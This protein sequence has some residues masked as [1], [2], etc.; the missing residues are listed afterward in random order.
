MN[1]VQKEDA[2]AAARKNR[3]AK[4]PE[5]VTPRAV[6]R[7]QALRA[8]LIAAAEKVIAG[9]GLAGLNARDLAEAVGCSLGAI[10]NVF[11]HLDAVV[12]EV[13]SRTLAMFEAFVARR[14]KRW[15]SAADGDAV[16]GLVALAEAYLDFAVTHYERWRT[17][18]VHERSAGQDLPASYVADQERLFLLVEKPLGALRPDLDDK[19]RAL[20]ARTMFAAVHGVVTLSLDEKVL[21]LPATVLSEQIR[22]F[23]RLVGIGILADADMPARRSRRT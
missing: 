23:V 9:K 8:D 12:F 21:S 2:V 17:L 20:L 22:T 19:R 5:A 10:Y 6:E 4:S 15:V 1:A 18:F 11:P 14:G 3:S 7:R 13:N 16:D